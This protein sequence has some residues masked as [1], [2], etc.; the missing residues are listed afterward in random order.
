MAAKSSVLI[1]FLDLTHHKKIFYWA[2]YITLFVVNA[3]GLALTVHQV[4]QCH[5]I[6]AGFRF[7]TLET[8]CSGILS[9]FL[10]SSPYNIATDI[11]ILLIPI[12]LLTRMT[13]P[14]RQKLI[15]IVTFGIAILT[16]V[17]DVIR[18]A[19]LE[20]TA[21]T[22]LREHHATNVGEVGN[23]NY[24]CLFL[25]ETLLSVLVP[26]SGVLTHHIAI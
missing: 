6:S 13:L 9:S 3:V 25:Q 20:D 21:I 23:R 14:F 16:I 15:L 26:Y 18:I 8:H 2:N 19:F 10:G 1:F 7:E 17:L 24:T 12:P 5:P 11:T 4:F 22:Q